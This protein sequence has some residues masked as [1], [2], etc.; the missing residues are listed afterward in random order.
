LRAPVEG[1][2]DER[3]VQAVVFALVAATFLTVYITQ[4]VLPI[5]RAEFGV[6]PGVA[7]LTVSA[8]VLGIALANLPFGVLADRF[9]V[10]PIVVAGGAVVAIA[11]VTCA[12][13]RSIGVLI[14][15][16]FVQGLF[17]P[18][19]TTCLAAYL[20]RTLPPRRL[21]VMMGWYVSATVTGGMGGR[22]LGGFVFPAEHWRLAFIGAAAIVA[23]AVAAAVHWLPR[24]PPPPRRETESTGFLRLLSRPELLRM[25]SVGFFAFFVFSAMFNYVPFYL[26]GPPLHA[27]VRVITLLYLAYVMGIAAGPLAGRLTNRFGTGATLVLGSLLFAAAIALTLI[28]S[29]VTIAAS[30]TAICG[31][32][33]AMHA[34]AVGSLNARLTESRGRA[35]SLY[36]LLYYLGGAAGISA[37][38]AAYARW[39]WPGVT[40]LGLAALLLPLAIGIAEMVTTRRGDDLVM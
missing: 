3:G 30:L 5:L 33:F 29:L 9:P 8:V 1:S 38:G 40:A 14:A 2:S 24:D 11:S 12:L 23:G 28:P 6:T 25:L 36:V 18:S 34:A 37:A 32:F 15:A 10:R 31:G 4:P 19:L 7:S 13:T 22:L 39:G 20:S 26:S 35:N 17:I 27:G 21:N 16:R